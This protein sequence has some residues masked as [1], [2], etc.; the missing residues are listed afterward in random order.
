[1]N[2]INTA[3]ERIAK[4]RVD[5]DSKNDFAKYDYYS[6]EMVQKLV[7]KGTEGLGLFITFLIGRDDTGL[8]GKL[9]VHEEGEKEGI[10]FSLPLEVPELKGM[11]KAQMY[12]SLQTYAKRYLLMNAFDITD[13]TL[14]FDSIVDKR[15]ELNN[16]TFDKI[17][18]SI[19]T[20]EAKE[21]AI[22]HLENYKDTDLKAILISKC[23]K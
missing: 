5:K 7:A 4:L 10:Y 14:D 1:M 11:N 15:K 18:S 13:N 8:M 9:W 12:G 3:R 17:M 16:A 23:Q 20:P 6:P 2:K 22:K 19:T 21:K